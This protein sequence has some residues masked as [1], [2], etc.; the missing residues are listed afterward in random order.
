MPREPRVYASGIAGRL[1][2]LVAGIVAVPLVAIGFPLVVLDG[3][4]DIHSS[5]ILIPV[6]V[7]IAV[8]GGLWV[9][10]HAFV[11][12]PVRI[13]TDDA[14]VRVRKGLRV[15][16]EWR[17][18]GTTFRSVVVRQRTNGLPSGS[19]RTIVA[20]TA[21]PVGI[22]QVEVVCRWF[23]A[24]TFTAAMADLAPVKQRLAEPVT[25]AARSRV[26]TIPPGA[27]RR[28]GTVA[29]PG[30]PGEIALTESTIRVDGTVWYFAQLSGIQ[31]TSPGYSDTARVLT[32]VERTGTRTRV[33]L[34]TPASRVFAE[35][36][37]FAALL[38]NNAPDGLVVFD[39][40]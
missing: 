16:H 5:K 40:A 12:G 29:R 34:G 11:T 10:V 28:A 3:M 37:E 13:E 7:G 38:A 19:T 36:D 15:A 30:I 6:C 27:G 32:L 39:L 33:P 1:S 21:G 18:D 22:E 23:T 25:G 9:L 4:L 31:L 26:F 8:V 2:A 24:A 14:T 35:Y 20:A 17:R